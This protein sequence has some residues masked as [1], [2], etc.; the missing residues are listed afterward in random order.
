MQV[1]CETDPRFLPDRYVE[2][3]CPHCGYAAAR[4]DQC[5]NC[6]RLLDPTDLLSPRCRLCGA[7]PVPR[8]SRQLFLDLPAMQDRLAS[9]LAGQER[10]RPN[11]RA[12]AR[13]LV[14]GGLQRRAATRDLEWGIPVPVEDFRDKVIYVWV[15]AVMGYL[16]ASMDWASRQGSPNAWRA[17]WWDPESRSYY[18]IGKDNIPFHAIIWP[19]ELLG[20]DTTINLPYDIPANEFLTLEGRQFST[21]RNWAVWLGDALDRYAPDALRYYL[22]AIA[23]E[24]ADTEF[25]FW[26]FVDGN[27][28]ELVSVWGNLVQRVV[29]FAARHWQGHVPAPGPR[30]PQDRA[31]LDKI[32]GAFETIGTLYAATHFKAALRTAMD[33]ARS[34]NRY[35]EA[36]SPWFE[37][38]S[39]RDAAA[40]TICTALRAIDALAIDALAILLPPWQRHV[41]SHDRFLGTRCVRLDLELPD[42][43]PDILDA[44]AQELGQLPQGNL[45]LSIGLQRQIPVPRRAIADVLMRI[46]GCLVEDTK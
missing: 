42:Q 46:D 40:T 35:L 17:W 28:H 3:T 11:V 15:E 26:G 24:T 12:F 38:A 45:A 13:N 33:L 16:T 32:D 21:S 9:Y 30:R 4:G 5:D 31:L 2:G 14:E 43:I 10:W 7:T 39:E 25:T 22:T 44:R 37:I 20:F 6:G 29:T 19:A 41:A 8:E 18:V 23:P 1:Y 36:C 34:V 27:N